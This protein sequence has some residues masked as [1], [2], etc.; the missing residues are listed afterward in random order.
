MAL[1]RGVVATPGHTLHVHGGAGW[2]VQVQATETHGQS[3][4]TN[5][6]GTRLQH[7]GA[8]SCRR[9]FVQMLIASTREHP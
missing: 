3:T 7:S 5:N 4:T 9:L 6:L 2:M 1:A 8:K